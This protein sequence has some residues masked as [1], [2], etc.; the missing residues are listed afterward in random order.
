MATSIPASSET[1]V[2]RLKKTNNP[3]LDKLKA[4][5]GNEAYLLEYLSL[6]N[7]P[8]SSHNDDK[9]MNRKATSRFKIELGTYSDRDNNE[10]HAIY[11]YLVC[12]NRD[13]KSL[14]LAA[15]YFP[16]NTKALGRRISFTDVYK[17]PSAQLFGIFRIVTTSQGL[18][19]L[20]KLFFI[21]YEI[22]VPGP[23]EFS[24]AFLADVERACR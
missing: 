19:A 18:C 11:A 12:N 3:V 20:V 2:P 16:T 5:L 17:S 9:R 8:I 7:I 15:Y 1:V 23:V 13:N 10:E 22:Q 6:H 14:E 4:E 21:H 24:P